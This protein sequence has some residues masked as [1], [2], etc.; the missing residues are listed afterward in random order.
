M[1]KL[2]PTKRKAMMAIITVA[3][4]PLLYISPLTQRPTHTYR[5]QRRLEMQSTVQ[6]K[7]WEPIFFKEINRRARLAKLSDLRRAN[8]SKDD[9]E[10]RVWIGFGLIPL[11]GFIIKKRHGQWSA[12]LLRSISPHLARHDYQQTLLAPKSGW[13]PFWQRLIEKGVLT[14]PD[15]IELEGGVTVPDGESF[16]VETNTGGS[17]RTYLYSNPHLQKWPEARTITEIVQSLLDEF[18]IPRKLLKAKNPS[19]NFKYQQ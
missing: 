17:Y 9:I 13:E 2:L 6:K 14:L 19:Q 5:S 4:L 3:L 11:E 7:A 1:I 12:L 10:L 15:S 18:G 16:V 8:L